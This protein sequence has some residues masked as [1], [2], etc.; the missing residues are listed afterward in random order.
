MSLAMI[1]TPPADDAGVPLG[2]ADWRFAIE[3]LTAD[4]FAA[5]W[6]AELWGAASIDSAGRKL[7]AWWSE[8]AWRDLTADAKGASWTDGAPAP[9]QRPETGEL[10]VT[11]K[12]NDRAYD[13]WNPF[14]VDRGYFTAGTI[15]RVVVFGPGGGPLIYQFTGII[16]SWLP[17]RRGQDKIGDVQVVAVA[18]TALLARIDNNALPAPYGAGQ[19]ARERLDLLLGEAAWPFGDVY[20][21]YDPPT[22]F[23]ATDMA[24]NRL[25]ECHVTADSVDSYFRSHRSGIAM[26]ESAD[27]REHPAYGPPSDSAW[28]GALWNVGGWSSYDLW[29]TA[30]PSSVFFASLAFVLTDT[31]PQDWDPPDPGGANRPVGRIAYTVDTLG[32]AN[33][34]LAMINDVR[35]AVAGSGSTFTALNETLFGQTGIRA[36]YT[37]NDLMLE[38]FTPL[39]NLATRILERRSVTL[40]V[41]D[42]LADDQLANEETLNMPALALVGVNDL[43]RVEVPPAR[44]LSIPAYVSGYTHDVTPVNGARVKWRST[45]QLST[46]PFELDS[47]DVWPTV[48]VDHPGPS[49]NVL[50]APHPNPL[51][52]F[53]Q[54]WLIGDLP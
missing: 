5:R 20:A 18:T 2:W 27:P 31:G 19:T 37:R 24:R 10:R 28:G 9:Y 25:G 4:P 29:Y 40:R 12:N 16:E 32:M 1:Q 54:L 52:L 17:E 7:G 51:L 46:L 3:L 45:F 36:T 50:T 13:P 47:I 8:P 44:G 33:D 42:V 53:E 35:L 39:P 26:L 41:T 22:S 21:E 49:Q 48:L 15:I 34:A 23:Q 30:R 6:G 43:C 14:A 11:L 38:S